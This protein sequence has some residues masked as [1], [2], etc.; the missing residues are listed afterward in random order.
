MQINFASIYRVQLKCREIYMYDVP[1]KFIQVHMPIMLNVCIPVL[2]VTLL[3]TSGS[4]CLNQSVNLTTTLHYCNVI[5]LQLCN[6]IM[7]HYNNII[8]FRTNKAAK[9]E[10]LIN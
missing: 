9:L 7:L 2:L 6:H 1:G 4:I 5:T 10:M 3:I 8:T